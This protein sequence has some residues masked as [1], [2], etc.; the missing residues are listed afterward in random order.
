MVYQWN[1][2]DV[3]A[4]AVCAIGGALPAL[5]TT[6]TVIVGGPGAFDNV[7][8]P[9]S[10]TIAVGDTVHW[11]WDGGLH[12]VESGVGGVHD[13]NFD[14]GAPVSDTATT[15]DLTFDQAF[16]TAN[17]MPNAEYPYYCELHW[18]LG[19]SGTITV[20]G[21]AIPTVSA[22]GLAVLVLAVV[23]VGTIVFGIRRRTVRVTA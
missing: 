12:D 3:I 21:G 4:F 22:W 2:S 17:P 23:T 11:D 8:T 6:H 9:A 7:Y 14:S 1:R 10:L 13:S 19:M 15:F 18:S 20:E 5:G 16:L